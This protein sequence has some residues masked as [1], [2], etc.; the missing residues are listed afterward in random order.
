[1]NGARETGSD[2]DR[3]EEGEALWQMTIYPIMFFS[4]PVG[5]W[6]ALK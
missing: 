6:G 1:M 3:N 2:Q 4:S 5:K